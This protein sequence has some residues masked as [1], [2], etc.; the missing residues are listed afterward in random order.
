MKL[1][2]LYDHVADNNNSTRCGLDRISKLSRE[3]SETKWLNE[4]N[5]KPKLRTYCLIKKTLNPSEY[6]KS[7]LYVKTYTQLNCTVSK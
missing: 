6:V 3:F 1:F 7:N 4:V 2:S 5:Q